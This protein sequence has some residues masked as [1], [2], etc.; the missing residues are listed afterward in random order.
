MS[1][2]DLVTEQP[3]SASL[4][5]IS[6]MFEP[7]VLKSPIDEYHGR[8]TEI[9]RFGSPNTL[10]TYPLLG[11]LLALN[12]VSATEA[13]FRSLL[14][15]GMELCPISQ[16]VAAEKTINLGGM[17]WHGRIGFSRSAFDHL[18]FSSA[19]DLKKASSTYVHF[20][21]PN[22]TF[23]TPLAEYDRVCHLRHGIVHNDGVLPGRNA[24]KLN[25]RRMRGLV[26]LVVD[27]R[28][29]QEIAAVTTTLV[30]TYNRELF[31]VFCHRWAV[32]WRNRADWCPAEE[33]QTFNKIWDLF[34]AKDEISRRRDKQECRRIDCLRA[35]R[36]HYDLD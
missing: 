9:L 19:D 36:A 25:I 12:V 14:S 35:V 13:F 28:R 26:R 18:S 29:L 23:Q 4:G 20:A 24:V 6:D 5:D 7:V 27:Y 21:L 10:D 17:L 34:A 22:A 11:R 8:I 3:P 32:D 2:A 1:L 16:S 31:S 30:A 15:A 33:T